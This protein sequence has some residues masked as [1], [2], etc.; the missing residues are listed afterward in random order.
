MVWLFVYAKRCQNA[1]IHL[2]KYLYIRS[3]WLLAGESSQLDK[4]YLYIASDH[5][6]LPL[7]LREDYQSDW[8]FESA[9]QMF[10]GY[11]C[12]KILPI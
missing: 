6:T 11:H 3:I 8:L 7:R 12:N 10:G 5:S 9:M 4:N 2:Q 1:R